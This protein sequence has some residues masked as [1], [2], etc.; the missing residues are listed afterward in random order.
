MCKVFW[1][2]ENKTKQWIH[3]VSLQQNVKFRNVV[4][5]IRGFSGKVLVKPFCLLSSCRVH[6]FFK[7]LSF[8]RIFPFLDVNAHAFLQG[9]RGLKNGGLVKYSASWV[10][11]VCENW[12]RILP[13]FSYQCFYEPEFVFYYLMLLKLET[14][15]KIVKWHQVIHIS[16]FL[17][18][19]EFKRVNGHVELEL[20][21]LFC[22]ATF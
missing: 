11:Q 17:R 8:N 21:I 10:K 16:F 1:F 3:S 9:Y 7:S 4:S 19:S 13:P 18:I 15:F 14:I 20:L 12:L 5:P 6:L 22:S 2:K